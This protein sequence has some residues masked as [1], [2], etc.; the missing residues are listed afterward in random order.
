MELFCLTSISIDIFMRLFSFSILLTCLL[1]SGCR[2]PEPS[3]DWQDIL[4]RSLYGADDIDYSVALPAIGPEWDADFNER[5]FKPW[6][7]EPD[8]LE[9]ALA[10][11]PGPD[12]TTMPKYLADPEY[13]GENKQRHSDKR[14]RQL[15]ENVDIR[16]FPTVIQ[17]GITLRHTNIRRLPLQQPGYDLYSKAGE[18]F[19]FDYFQETALWANSPVLLL[20]QT[21]D[22]AWAYILCSYYKGWIPR[23]EVALVDEGFVREWERGTYCA[24]LTDETAV[25]TVDGQFLF[26]GKLGMVLP[27]VPEGDRPGY[28]QVYAAV[29]DEDGIAVL[30]ACRLPETQAAPKPMAFTGENLQP[31]IRELLGN[32][33][34]WGGLLENRDCSS[35]I[36]D[37]YT[38]FGIWTPRNSS[39][40]SHC[41]ETT[42]E[43]PANSDE[44]IAVIKEK[45]VPFLTI[46]YKRGHAMLYVGLDAQGEP[47]IFHTVWGLKAYYDDPGLAAVLE[48][49]PLEGMHY[50]QDKGLFEGRKLIGQTAITTL[51]IGEED[52]AVRQRIVDELT[53]MTVLEDVAGR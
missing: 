47:L 33:Y 31:L 30:K 20:H 49:Y 2:Q 11:V 5:Y 39:D 28:R 43:L 52:P 4:A 34:G 21:V 45:G 19:P 46:L 36:K 24:V 12:S 25:R 10:Q 22:G 8:S 17:R 35:S 3:P 40:Q 18:G 7:M 41:G 14:R 27:H 13:Y 37:L 6:H 15:R 53:Y 32:P 23:N 51:T 9:A 50:N 16:G 42:I 44:K 48:Q 26:T 29:A 1:L 38:P